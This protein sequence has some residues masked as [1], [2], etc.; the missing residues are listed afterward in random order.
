MPETMVLEKCAPSSV[1]C[2]LALNSILRP[3]LEKIWNGDLWEFLCREVKVIPHSYQ[4]KEGAFEGPQCNKILNSVEE[5]IKP[6]LLALGEPG[7]LYLDFLIEFKKF[8]DTFFGTVLPVNFLDV[9]A[10]FKTQ[11]NLL[12]TVGKVPI[13][14][15]LHIMAEHVIQWV[16]K[17]GRALG[18]ES[19][20]A[21]E[22]AHASFDELWGSFSVNDDRSEAYLVNGKKAILKFNTDHTNAKQNMISEE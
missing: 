21:V 3:Q 22:A 1:H 16:E 11:L 18:E 17:H 4:G 2:L 14:P 13:T 8:K 9:A 7:M 10:G 6:H 5:T 20:Q 19:E 12:H 15:K